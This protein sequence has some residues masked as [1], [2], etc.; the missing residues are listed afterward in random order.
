MQLVANYGK[1][2]P[3][4]RASVAPD[5]Y[6]GLRRW[7]CRFVPMGLWRL[8]L[9]GSVGACAV[10]VVAAEVRVLLLLLIVVNSVDR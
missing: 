10:V 5:L 4:F 7:P 1:W 9:G 6:V 8:G 3:A 2:Q